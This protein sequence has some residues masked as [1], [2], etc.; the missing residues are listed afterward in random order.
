MDFASSNIL[1]KRSKKDNDRKK[2]SKDTDERVSIEDCE[3]ELEKK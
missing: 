1:I 2:E 3:M